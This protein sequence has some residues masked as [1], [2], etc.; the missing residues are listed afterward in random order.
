[1]LGFQVL[2]VGVLPTL[3]YGRYAVIVGLAGLSQTITS[4]G[5]PRVAARFLSGGRLSSG[6]R[7]RLVTALLGVR[8]LLTLTVA[9]L[10]GLAVWF[11]RPND[12]ALYW[13]GAAYALASTLLLDAD[14]VALALGRQIASRR[15]A[16]GEPVLRLSALAVMALGGEARAE[17]LLWISA[18][19]A[20]LAAAAL[21]VAA[22]RA[23]SPSVETAETSDRL[24]WTAIRRIAVGGYSGTLSWLA[25]S[26]GMVRLI[27]SRSLPPALF[28]G[29]AF[30]QSLVISLQRYMPS[31]LL[32][33]LLEPP[34]MA[35]AGRPGRAE[36]LEAALSMVVK[37]DAVLVGGAI[38]AAGAA[39]A[40][41]VL[42]LT[43][44]RYGEAGVFAPWLL[45]GLVANASH[46]SYEIAA[47]SLGAARVL[48]GVLW[49]T[50]LWLAIA[51]L[52][53][54]RWGVWPLLLCPL[55]EALTRL[56][57]IERALP[58]RDRR[59]GKALVD[60]HHLILI[61]VS[62]ALISVLAAA[63]SRRLGEGPAISLG[64]GLVFALSFLG[65]VARLAPLR[66]S[67]AALLIQSAP[68]M[69]RWLK[70]PN[71]G[72]ARVWVL[73]PRGLGGVGGVDRLMDSLRPL[74][75]GRDGLKVQFLT[76]R[77][78]NRG[79]SP[80]V[81]L[82][83]L[84]RLATASMMGRC[85]LIHVN[86]GSD[87]SCYRK[88]ALLAVPRLFN[89]P[90]VVHLHGSAF[91]TFWSTAS[92]PVRQTIDR[93][94]QDAAHVVVLGRAWRTLLQERLPS[95]RTV[96]LANATPRSDQRNETAAEPVQI[97]F[98]GEL[99]P[100][101][102][103]S[104]L[105]E[106]L[107]RLNED[108]AWRAVIAGDGDADALRRQAAKL[109]LS[110]KVHVPGWV[111]PQG[112]QALLAASH[113]LALPSFEETL[114]MAVI[115]AFASGL[116]VVATPVGALPDILSH[117]ENGMFIAPGDVEGLARTLTLLR[118]RPALRERLGCA[119][120]A[121]HRNDLSIEPYAERLCSIWRQS[122]RNESP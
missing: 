22:L 43:H 114:P 53:A 65:V 25:F 82:W 117:K 26:P 92:P 94:F 97:L 68:W 81:T 52:T 57:L 73:T 4:V 102:G 42:A 96:V 13:P 46:R 7:R 34:L 24:D 98:L 87:G 66:P 15:A 111:G 1:L 64:V 80:F 16:V 30:A 39:G 51:V 105:I 91:E 21:I 2:A 110:T 59:T 90:Y 109:N 61:G 70:H 84:M 120:R 95:L 11:L 122:L 17:V 78:D 55:G 116:A 18:A 47:I 99:G 44:G 3:D 27:A 28:A 107:G 75:A 19:S 60:L 72:R 29:F 5:L 40:P 67:Q 32:F 79:L 104:L 74:M 45:L 20:G 77:G 36:R 14:G 62:A 86:L 6:A 106:A 71:T 85:D 93:L 54:Q 118:D 101:K 31:F 8:L 76:T 23:P 49:L 63:V 108:K 58:G 113:I 48:T 41:A 35:E 10:T 38:I 37:L 89:V 103:A 83:A 112:V 121:R 119:A 69:V 56:W 88:L 12:G 33:P 50:L 115:E 100:R 9:G